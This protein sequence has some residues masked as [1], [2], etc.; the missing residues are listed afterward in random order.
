MS[1]LRPSRA[2]EIEALAASSFRIWALVSLNPFALKPQGPNKALKPQ[3]R[4]PKPK[5]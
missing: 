2:F 1:A 4:K 3:K 5:P